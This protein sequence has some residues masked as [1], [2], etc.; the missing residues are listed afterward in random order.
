[1]SFLYFQ[2]AQSQNR[3]YLN[4]TSL[5]MNIGDV[6]FDDAADSLYNKKNAK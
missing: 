4:A 6:S 5:M 1:M 3:V 2:I